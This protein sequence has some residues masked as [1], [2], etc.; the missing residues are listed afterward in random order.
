MNAPAFTVTVLRAL[1]GK[2]PVKV[3]ATD[4]QGRVIESAYDSPKWLT[5]AVVG[6][7]TVNG[8]ASLL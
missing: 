4:R 3:F 7:E 2:K 5:S 1:T 8:L 6:V